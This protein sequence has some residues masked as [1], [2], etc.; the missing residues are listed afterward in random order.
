[1]AIKEPWVKAEE[2]AKHLGVSKDTVY[3]W[4]DVRGLPAHK[5]GRLYRFKISEIDSWVFRS[6]AEG[7][8]GAVE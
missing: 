3:R 8:S 7:G 4:I 6:G 5:V 2:I 1:M